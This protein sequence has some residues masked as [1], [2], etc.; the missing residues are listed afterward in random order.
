MDTG[1]TNIS[2]IVIR[3][4]EAEL[5]VTC[6]ALQNLEKLDLLDALYTSFMAVRL[7]FV[8]ASL[9]SVHMSALNRHVS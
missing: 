5:C 8:S 3:Y 7:H 4:G 1:R 2:F 9:A 6:C